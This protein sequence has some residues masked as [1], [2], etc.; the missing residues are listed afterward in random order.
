MQMIEAMQRKSPT[1]RCAPSDQRSK[2]SIN[3]GVN[4]YILELQ[5]IETDHL[6]SKSKLVEFMLSGSIA[7]ADKGSSGHFAALKRVVDKGAM[8]IRQNDCVVASIA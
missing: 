2:H 7:A 8:S 4:F 5:Q 3:G 6:K 1:S